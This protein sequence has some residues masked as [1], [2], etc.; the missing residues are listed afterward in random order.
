MAF[1]VAEGEGLEH[2]VGKPVTIAG[3]VDALRDT[4]DLLRT[5]PLPGLPPLTGGLVG[6]ITHF[7]NDL[8][9]IQEAT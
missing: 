1:A 9:T 8:L 4:V 5:T 6:R 7:D 3:A 2:D